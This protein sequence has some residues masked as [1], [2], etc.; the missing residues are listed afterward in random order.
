M[1]QI[2]AWFKEGSG[3]VVRSTRPTFGRCPAVPA[4][5]PDP[6]LNDAQI[7][8]TWLRI[9]QIDRCEQHG[10]VVMNAMKSGGITWFLPPAR[11]AKRQDR[12]WAHVDH[13]T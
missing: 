13:E 5:D 6:F 1:S 9:T 10:W 3:T 8:K 11:C 12:S 2:L 4:T 7:L